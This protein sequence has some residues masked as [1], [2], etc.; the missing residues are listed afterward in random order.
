MTRLAFAGKWSGLTTPLDG[1]PAAWPAAESRGFNNEF[2]ATIPSPAAPRPRNVRR[3]I[4]RTKSRFMLV[5]L[6][7]G[8]ALIPRDQFV[9]VQDRPGDSCHR[10]NHGWTPGVRRRRLACAHEAARA[11]RVRGKTFQAAFVAAAQNGALGRR[12]RETQRE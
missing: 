10:R 1:E 2:S 4:S 3:L 6:I 7:P 12:G 8:R 5:P 11:L 9:Q